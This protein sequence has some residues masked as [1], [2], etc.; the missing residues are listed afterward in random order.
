M[1]VMGD[2]R[3][4]SQ[5]ARCQG[6]VPIENVIGRAFVV[7]WPTQRL[8]QPVRARR[9]EDVRCRRIRSRRPAPVRLRSA[10]DPAARR[11]VVLPFLLTAALSARSGLPLRDSAS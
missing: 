10:T 8:H 6:P 11:A 5:D 2:H 9:L 7:V 4:V 1:F 3:L